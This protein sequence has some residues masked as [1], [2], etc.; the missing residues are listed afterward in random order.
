MAQ[1][2]LWRTLAALLLASSVISCGGRQGAVPE[3]AAQPVSAVTTPT[4]AIAMSETA[5]TAIEPPRPATLVAEQAG[6]QVNLRSQPTTKADS[7]GYGQAGGAVLLLRL[8]EGEGGY[9]WYYVQLDQSTTQGW[10]R[11]DFVQP[12]EAGAAPAAS[13]NCGQDLQQALFETKTLQVYICSSDGDLRYLSVNK[14]TRETVALDD[15]QDSQGTY[16]AIDGNQQYHVNDGTLAVYRV[17]NGE[18]TQLGGEQVIK[19]QRRK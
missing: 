7:P 9:T 15:V 17:N 6:A 12:A 1:R 8:I 19:H 5:G 3:D 11:G 2:R 10:V 14:D 13:L 4:P 16:V 18:Y